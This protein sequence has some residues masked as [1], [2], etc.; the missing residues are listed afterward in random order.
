MIS[1]FLALYVVGYTLP[2]RSPA[3][4]MA[5]K[6]SASPT[7]SNANTKYAKLWCEDEYNAATGEAEE[8]CYVPPHQAEQNDMD[9]C[10]L[11]GDYGAGTRWAVRG[12]G[13]ALT[14]QNIMLTPSLLFF[15]SLLLYIAVHGA[16]GRE[17]R[18]GGDQRQDDVGPLRPLASYAVSVPGKG[19]AVVSRPGLQCSFFAQGPRNRRARRHPQCFLFGL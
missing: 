1:A 18:G 2:T 13:G 7:T 11:L 8:V 5:Q 3:A 12:G 19:R 17:R 10:M 14:P 16:H 9:S 15:W 4:T 6:M